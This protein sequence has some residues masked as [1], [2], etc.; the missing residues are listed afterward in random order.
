[1]L[2]WFKTEI[3]NWT[4]SD[5]YLI[6]EHRG[7]E[8]ERFCSKGWRPR[9]KTNKKGFLDLACCQGWTGQQAANM[10]SQILMEAKLDMCL[11]RQK[12]A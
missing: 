9:L 8:R 7:Q 3:L 12:L 5:W 6:T 10:Q 11:R 4:I 2:N 1:M